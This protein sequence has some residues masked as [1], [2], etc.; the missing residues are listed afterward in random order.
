MAP[1]CEQAIVCRLSRNFDF[2][3][4]VTMSGELNKGVHK[5]CVL[6]KNK[7]TLLESSDDGNMSITDFYPRK[8]IPIPKW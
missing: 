2:K 5:V 6:K 8:T 7:P 4:T 1:V 3:V